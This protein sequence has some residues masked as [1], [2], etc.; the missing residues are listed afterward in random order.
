M[1]G[2]STPPST[3]SVFTVSCFAR[4]ANEVA[5]DDVVS[6]MY[7]DRPRIPM[8]PS[9]LLFYQH[10]KYAIRTHWRST[11]GQGTVR[12]RRRVL[13]VLER[14]HREESTCSWNPANE[15]ASFFHPR[16]HPMNIYGGASSEEGG[17]NVSIGSVSNAL[18]CCVHS[19]RVG[20]VHWFS[21]STR[22]SRPCR[23]GSTFASNVSLCALST[24]TVF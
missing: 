2:V 14:T 7:S 13:L 24:L 10:A 15:G 17:V 5:H 23:R 12:L 22:E 3:T 20:V 19:V 18:S 16:A 9:R 1:T 8:N 11:K 6:S 21:P 4:E